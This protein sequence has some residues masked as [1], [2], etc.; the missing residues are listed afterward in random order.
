MEMNF[1]NAED[2]IT[3]ESFLAWHYQTDKKNSAQWDIWLATNQ[4]NKE[5]A[6]EAFAFLQ[7]I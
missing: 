5:I 3:D 7:K 1:N 2:L 4:G 6:A